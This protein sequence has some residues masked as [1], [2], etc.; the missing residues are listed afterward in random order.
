MEY[1]FYF[2]FYVH[3]YWFSGDSSCSANMFLVLSDFSFCACIY[4]W[5]AEQQWTVLN[6]IDRF[7]VEYFCFE[8]FFKCTTRSFGSDGFLPWRYHSTALIQRW[9]GRSWKIRSYRKRGRSLGGVFIGI[10][11][12]NFFFL[13]F[14]LA[15]IRHGTGCFWSWRN[16]RSDMVWKG[17]GSSITRRGN[18]IGIKNIYW[19]ISMKL[20]QHY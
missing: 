20:F 17:W 12:I 9:Q 13:K 8:P 10:P 18:W 14:W 11:K 6:R 1:K 5:I 4:W 7:A 16:K 2:W 15:P 19:S 3:L